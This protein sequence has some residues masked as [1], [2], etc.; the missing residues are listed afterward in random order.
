MF[1]F[2]DF[3]RIAADALH[4]FQDALEQGPRLRVVP[5]QPGDRPA[6]RACV[7][8]QAIRRGQFGAE[9]GDG[10]QGARFQPRF[11]RLPVVVLPPQVDDVG[12][13]VEQAE[14]LRVRPAADVYQHGQVAGA[15]RLQQVFEQA[16]RVD[17]FPALAQADLG[18]A[19]VG[20]VPFAVGRGAQQDVRHLPLAQ[21][22][23]EEVGE[24]GFAAVRR[25][26]DEDRRKQIGRHIGS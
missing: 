11:P 7:R 10:D 12:A 3:R 21:A 17:P 2:Q 24:D 5:V 14:L 15:D 25:A 4:P 23:G 9:D 20:P 13:G 26:G 1:G 22:P 8:F 16:G 6:Q 18:G 19:F